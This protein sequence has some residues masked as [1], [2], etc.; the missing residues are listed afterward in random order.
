MRPD[1]YI[2]D[3][4][5]DCDNEF[6]NF[7]DK[8]Y[9]FINTVD[10]SD[11][12]LY[13]FHVLASLDNCNELR[14]NGI[15]N[16]QEVLSTNTILASKLK[17]YEIVFDIN[18][19]TLNCNGK[20]YTIDFDYYR[21]KTRLTD[22]EEAL[23]SI[24]HRVYYDYCVNGFFLN[25]DVFDYGGRVHERP[26]FLWVLSEVF[27]QLKALVTYWEQNS[28]SYRIDFFSTINQLQ[29]FTFELDEWRNPPYEGWIEL[30]DDM[31]IKKWMLSHA[32]RRAN[33]SQTEE[34]IY[35][36]DDL[37]IPPSQIVSITEIS[38]S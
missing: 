23:S 37:C 31:K 29:R 17:E 12:K 11:L 15:R 33:G 36:K 28:K 20:S 4:I 13:A 10:I 27:T 22:E 34:Y 25:D 7:W 3:L 26:E 38:P 18:N 19:H 35:I 14:E 30:D 6:E 1:E 21:N 24:A 9:D 5:V 8:H 32:I 2:I 16:L